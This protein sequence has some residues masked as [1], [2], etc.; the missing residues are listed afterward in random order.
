MFEYT[1]FIRTS[2]AEL[3]GVE[4]LEEYIKDRITPFLF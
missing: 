2:D 3:R 1:P 4:H